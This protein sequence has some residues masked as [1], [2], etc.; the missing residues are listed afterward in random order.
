MNAEQAANLEELLSQK[1]PAVTTAFLVYQTEDG[2]WVADHD[3]S[4]KEFELTRNATMDDIIAGVS[5]IY[6][7]ATAQQ[8]AAATII[9]MEQRAQVMQQ[10]MRQ[11]AESNK[12]A[13]LIDPSKLRN[14]KA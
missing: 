2:Q 14:P 5:A 11:Q 10:Q 6:A 1:A 7:G 4:G 8:T 12:I 9:M 13:S 3:I